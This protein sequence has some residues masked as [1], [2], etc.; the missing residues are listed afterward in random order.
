V[1]GLRPG[2]GSRNGVSVLPPKSCCSSSLAVLRSAASGQT[3]VSFVKSIGHS[4]AS[5]HATSARS[6]AIATARR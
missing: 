4:A 6:H 5:R 2:T 3:L 1:N